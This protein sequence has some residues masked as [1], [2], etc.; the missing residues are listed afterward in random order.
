MECENGSVRACVF[1]P[2]QDSWR[3][4]S[5]LLLVQNVGNQFQDDI[6]RAAVAALDGTDDIERA[7]V[8]ALGGSIMVLGGT[9]ERTFHVY[10]SAQDT[11][12]RQP[13]P[14]FD[15]CRTQSI[16]VA[17]RLWCYASED[18]LQETFIYDPE[19]CSWTAGPRLPFE[20]LTEVE[21]F[22]GTP[23]LSRC[24]VSSASWPYFELTPGTA[25]Y[26]AFVWDPAREAWDEAP[27]PVPP[28]V[29]FDCSQIIDGHLIVSSNHPSEQAPVYSTSGL[30]RLFVLSPGSTEWTE[31]RLPDGVANA[32]R[33][34]AVRIG[35]SC[36][37]M[38]HYT[39]LRQPREDRR[40]RL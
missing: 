29:G 14:P 19:T 10:D 11:W 4:I 24:M 23:T 18:H 39:Y 16:E 8:A 3:Y 15:S 26:S 31:W 37:R 1:D 2:R 38:F 25:G 21:E 12:S 28:V 36:L 27:F 13:P 40:R 22:I 9:S 32:T 20:L 5:P 17:G 33:V 30:T 6:E 34:A 35:W 7:A